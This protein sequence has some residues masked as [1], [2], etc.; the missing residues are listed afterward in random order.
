MCSIKRVHLHA[1]K[2]PFLLATHSSSGGRARRKSE[3]RANGVRQKKYVVPKL[4]K[5]QRARRQDHFYRR[6]REIAG[7][8][9]IYSEHRLNLKA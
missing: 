7:R 9:A 2:L 6:P 1:R 8:V 4:A 5:Y 3:S